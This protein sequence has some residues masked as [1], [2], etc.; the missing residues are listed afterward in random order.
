MLTD[1]KAARAILPFYA[2]S[3]IT[4]F[5]LCHFAHDIKWP[6]VASGINLPTLVWRLSSSF[7]T[8]KKS[9]KRTVSHYLP[10]VHDLC[11]F[12]LPTWKNACDGIFTFNSIAVLKYKWPN[13]PNIVYPLF[14]IWKYVFRFQICNN[15]SN[16]SVFKWFTTKSCNWQKHLPFS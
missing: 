1:E 12:T 5:L 8:I 6:K 3:G 13:I 14:E 7:C 4:Y 9:M 16:L 11:G 10:C 2:T 15:S